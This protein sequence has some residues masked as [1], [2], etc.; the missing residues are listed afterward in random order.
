MPKHGT[1]F[2]LSINIHVSPPPSKQIKKEKSLRSQLE[3]TD[4]AVHI[5]LFLVKRGIE[6]LWPLLLSPAAEPPP[7]PPPPTSTSTGADV[8]WRGRKREAQGE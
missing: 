7:Q 8:E 1:F 5:Q 6:W 3:G 2:L 4:S